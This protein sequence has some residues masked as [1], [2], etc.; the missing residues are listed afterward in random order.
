M[1]RVLPLDD[2]HRQAEAIFDNSYDHVE[3]WLATD[4]PQ[5]TLTSFPAVDDNLDR[6]METVKHIYEYQRTREM[7]AEANAA[8]TCC[9]RLRAQ[10][11]DVTTGWCLQLGSKE[12]VRKRLLIFVDEWDDAR[13]DEYRLLDARWAWVYSRYFYRGLFSRAC[14]SGDRKAHALFV[15]D[16]RE[17]AMMCAMVQSLRP[18]AADGGA[19]FDALYESYHRTNRKKY[20]LMF[21]DPA[22]LAVVSA[23]VSDGAPPPA[24]AAPV[25]TSKAAGRGKAATD[26]GGAEGL[27]LL[28]RGATGLADADLFGRSD[29]YCCVRLGPAGSA[30]ADKDA[31]TE[32]V[33]TTAVDST[34]PVWQ[35][36]VQYPAPVPSSWEVHLAI[37]DRDF[38]SADDA[39]GEARVPVATLREHDNALQTFP[40][41]AASSDGGAAAAKAPG[42]VELMAGSRV[43]AQLV[44]EV[45]APRMHALRWMNVERHE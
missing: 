36:A 12:V 39:L 11:V 29:A 25:A 26:D 2:A 31:A 37:R 38:L 42:S 14:C 22:G 35:L 27:A 17:T 15:A 30:F 7:A 28:V 9:A 23:D 21:G 10:F 20:S 1:R 40:L 19:H 18:G 6:A 24:T 13:L 3:Q 4:F 32:R 34:S 16:M 45:N 33:S 41:H 43:E 8:R 44:D 5:W